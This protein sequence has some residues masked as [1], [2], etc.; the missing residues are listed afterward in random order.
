MKFLAL[1]FET[2]DYG[3]DSACALGL[4][5]VEEGRVVRKESFLIKPPRA[6]FYF[7]WVHGITWEDVRNEPT[8]AE[9]WPLIEEMARGVSFFVAHNASFDRGVL[10][11]CCARYGIAVP[12]IPFQ[13]TVKLSRRLWNIRPTNLPSVC[14]HFAIPLNHHDA[15]S[16]T[17][18]CAEI[19]IRAL[20][21][22]EA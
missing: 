17:E 6:S 13:C 12:D 3:P 1:D 4:V 18:A 16:D 5:R 19:M 10:N 21:E 22:L 20:K 7:T 14:R 9:R 15:L 2:A 8:F 11:A